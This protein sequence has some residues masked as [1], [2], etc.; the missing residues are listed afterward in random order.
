[1][2]I[3]V[4]FAVDTEFA[5]W[6]KLRRFQKNTNG[7][8]EFFSARSGGAEVNVL[9]T[10]VGGKRAWVEATKVIW[11]GNVDVCISSGLAGALRFDYRV[12]DVLAA[13]EVHAIG[14]KSVVASDLGLIHLAEKQG[15]R[16][17]GS[18]YTADHVVSSASEKQQLGKMA[19]AVEMESGEVLYEAAAF[20]AKAVAIRGVSDTADEDLP[21]DFN[22]VVTASGDVSIPRVLGEV[23]R[24]PLSTPALVKFGN[25]SKM[26][27]EK[28]A[29]FLDRYV[30]AVAFSVTA[31]VGVAAR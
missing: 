11:D 21:L 16:C 29:A 22:K 28:L 7:V 27:A 30:E 3:L 14:W 12:G 8:T 9:L 17:V 2:R 6:R 13:R 31:S 15:A 23:L 1:M 19:D 18:F 25:Q 10:G 4:T 24:H 26:A 5:P 20:G